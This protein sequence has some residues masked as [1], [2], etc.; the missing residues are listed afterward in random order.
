ML[1]DN[2]IWFPQGGTSAITGE[3]TDQFFATKGA[4]ELASFTF[5]VSGDEATEQKSGAGTAS[6]KAKF[7]EF[8]VEKVV[9]SASVALYKACCQAT[10]FPTIMIAIRKAGGDQLMFLQYIFRYNQVT[11]VTWSGGTGQERPKETL[12]FI[13]KAMG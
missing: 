10:I 4:S 9:D 11:S 12:K 13:F 1:S 5:T 6:G 7:G 8:T 3:T 2:F